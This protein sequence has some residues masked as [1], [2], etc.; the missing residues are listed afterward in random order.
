MKNILE[1]KARILTKSVAEQSPWN[2]AKRDYS[3]GKKVLKNR[4]K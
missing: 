1:N 3:W 2:S 4:K